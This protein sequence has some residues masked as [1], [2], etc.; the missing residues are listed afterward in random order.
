MDMMCV[1]FVDDL[2]WRKMPH[3]CAVLLYMV[4]CLLFLHKQVSWGGML[5]L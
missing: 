4:Y 3:L 5:I 1:F 2:E